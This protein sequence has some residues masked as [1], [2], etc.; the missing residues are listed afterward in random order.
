MFSATVGVPDSNNRK[1]YVISAC[2]H[3][4]VFLTALSQASARATQQPSD[5]PSVSDSIIV[6]G[7]RVTLLDARRLS[8]EE[9]RLSGGN[10]PDLWAGGGFHFAFL[11]E[12]RPGQTIPAVL[13]EIRVL[14]GSQPYNSV[15]NANSSKPFAPFVIFQD[16]ENF[17]SGTVY[18][19]SIRKPLRPRTGATAGVT[20]AGIAAA[21]MTAGPPASTFEPDA[22]LQ[23]ASRPPTM[24]ASA[25]VTYVR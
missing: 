17:L 14:I 15:T 22:P 19:R 4:L 13:G 18:G 10:A 21:G 1:R 5:L 2:I 11:V 8:A 3:A 24:T 6:D 20:A 23:A 9:Y 16:V 7:M 25:A 12:N